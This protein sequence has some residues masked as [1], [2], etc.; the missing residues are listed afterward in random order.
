MQIN[1]KNSSGA[2]KPKGLKRGRGLYLISRKFEDLT[3][4]CTATEL[5]FLKRKGLYSVHCN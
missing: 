2:I 4:K 3:V 5:P 1:F